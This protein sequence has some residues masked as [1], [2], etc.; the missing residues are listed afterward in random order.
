MKKLIY[1]VVCFLFSCYTAIEKPKKPDNLISEEK[2]VDI[3]YDVFLLNS[4]KGVNK[5]V[6]E[7]N[8]VLPEKYVFEK[9]KIDSAQ[10]ANSN[11]YYAYDT[12]TYESILNRIK[13][14]IDL[15]KKE[16][17]ALEK[18]EEA[19]RK[20]KAD[21]IREVRAKEK[22][23]LLKLGEKIPVKKLQKN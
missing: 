7:L 15:K 2:M 1:I 13:E 22:D 19:E 23:S 9:Y 5:R 11:N 16:Y 18:V 12:K 14:K 3:M 10:F 21:S 4:A 17:E 6:L 20:R 8:G